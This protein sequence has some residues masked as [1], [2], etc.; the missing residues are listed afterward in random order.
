MNRAN[1]ASVFRWKSSRD[2][3]INDLHWMGQLMLKVLQESLRNE[4]FGFCESLHCSTRLRSIPTLLASL[5][6][7]VV[8]MDSDI[9][10]RQFSKYIC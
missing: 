3:K 1:S 6:L 2:N 5:I 4:N 10:H 7:F 9:F 8:Q